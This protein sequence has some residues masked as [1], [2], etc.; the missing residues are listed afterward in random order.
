V[1]ALMREADDLECVGLVSINRPDDLSE[2]NWRPSLEEADPAADLL[3][4]FTLP[5]GTGAA[6]QWCARHQVAILSGTTGLSEEDDRALRDAALTVPVL[7]APNLSRGVALTTE[8]VRRAAE[9]LGPKVPAAIADIH[10]QYKL[11]APSGTALALGAAVRQGFSQSGANA[12]TAGNAEPEYS[13][14][15]EGEVIGEHTVSFA[16]P[17]ERLEITHRALDRDVFARGALQAGAWLV[18]QKPGFYSTGDWL[19][20]N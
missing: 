10:H 11:D 18:R 14:V 20:L 3:I 1:L 7:W 2:F 13:S 16:M 8:L 9:A 12:S 17:D 4:D 15:R 5:G 6:A 19:A